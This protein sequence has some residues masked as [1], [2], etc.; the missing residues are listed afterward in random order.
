[1]KPDEVGERVGREPSA[2]FEVQRGTDTEDVT[3]DPESVAF[4]R[5]K[6]GPL[7]LLNYNKYHSFLPP[8]H[9]LVSF[10]LEGEAKATFTMPEYQQTRITGDL[11]TVE[12]VSPAVKI[13]G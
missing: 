10:T 3:A 1:M 5:H 7:V 11:K 13:Y 4:G 2:V 9:A 12:I 6:S 8:W